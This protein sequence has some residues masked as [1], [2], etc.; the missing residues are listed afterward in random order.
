MRDRSEFASEQD[1]RAHLEHEVN[2]AKGRGDKEAL[3]EALSA[4]AALGGQRAA[5]KR[6]RAMKA[7]V[8]KRA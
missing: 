5:E 1:Y 3:D 6:P 7:K 4:L 8:E 2:A